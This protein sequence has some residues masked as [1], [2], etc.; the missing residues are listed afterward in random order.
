MN[1]FAASSAARSPIPEQR[2]S[3]DGW[4]AV[5]RRAM[6]FG[7]SRPR[8]QYPSS[9]PPWRRPGSP[10]RGTTTSIC[11]VCGWTA[12]IKGRAMAVRS[13]STVWLTPGPGA[14][15]GP[16]CWGRRSRSP[17]RPTGPSPGDT[18]SGRWMPPLRD[19]GSWPTLS[20]GPSPEAQGVPFVLIEVDTLE[21]AKALPCVF[22]DYAVFYHGR[23][24][25]V[26]LLDTAYL[27]RILKK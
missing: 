4:P 3:G 13:W 7:S 10:S 16:V 25:T 1:T 19:T 9:T 24:E 26:N 23:F 22:N 2:R 18:G 17:G 11:T 8:P 12:P 15:P 14:D 20:T 5:S 27:K 21:E 6:C